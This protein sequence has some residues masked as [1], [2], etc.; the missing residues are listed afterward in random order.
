MVDELE[1]LSPISSY[2][3]CPA[4]NKDLAVFA[5]AW[6]QTLDNAAAR[7]SQRQTPSLSR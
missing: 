6:G 2:G 5:E 1:S 7:V 3:K 4:V